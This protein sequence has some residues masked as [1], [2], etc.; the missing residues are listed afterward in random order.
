MTDSLLTLTDDHLREHKHLTRSA[1]CSLK[2]APE[3]PP[4]HLQPDGFSPTSFFLLHQ[5]R[6]DFAFRTRHAV[7]RKRLEAPDFGFNG[8][9]QTKLGIVVRRKWTHPG[10][11]LRSPPPEE[12]S[13]SALMLSGTYWREHDR[14]AR[15]NSV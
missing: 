2:T 7:T 1:S 6:D 4:F 5:T 9:K 3:A 14:A 11:F 8:E 12:R 15:F 13:F 10:K